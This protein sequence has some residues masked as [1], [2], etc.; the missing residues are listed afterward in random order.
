[1]IISEYAEHAFDKIQHLIRIKNKTS[2]QVGIEL[3]KIG[4]AYL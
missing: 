4:K 3:S 2:Q 1:M